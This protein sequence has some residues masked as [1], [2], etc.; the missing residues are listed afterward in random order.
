MDE[1]RL[2]VAD[3]PGDAGTSS[4]IA[5]NGTKKGKAKR[6]KGKKKH[7]SVLPW[8]LL[9]VFV[10]VTFL[11]VAGLKWHEQPGFCATFC[12]E[13]M[14]SYLENYEEGDGLARIHKEANV[15][16][17]DCH[18]PSIQQQASEAMAQITGDYSVPLRQRSFDDEMCL[19]CHISTEHLQAKTDLLEKD[20]HGGN[21]T[22]HQ[23][24]TCNNCHKS[25]TDQVNQ[26]SR[27]HDPGNQRM[28]TYPLQRH[29]EVESE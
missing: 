3:D 20:P 19:K 24:F 17:L 15:T 9:I 14:G 29:P 11:A 13:T 2:D 8:T 10:A 4:Q 23:S 26:C 1:E 12:H 22:G 18:E 5:D 7:P 6:E 25:H 27:C 28:I 21:I 16:C